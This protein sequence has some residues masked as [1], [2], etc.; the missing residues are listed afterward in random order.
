MAPK[1]QK[2]QSNSH[3][4]PF[5]GVTSDLIAMKH[6]RNKILPLPWDDHVDNKQ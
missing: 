1:P 6:R 3:T 5:V 4:C 2:E